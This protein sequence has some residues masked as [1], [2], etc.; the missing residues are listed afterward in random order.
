MRFDYLRLMQEES[1]DLADFLAGLPDDDWNQPT[2]CTGWRV[3]EVV[4]HMAAGHTIALGSYL[5]LLATAGFSADRAADRLA[6]QFAASHGNEAILDEF[7]RGTAGQPKGPAA[8]VPR[9][10]LFTDH[11][12]H[13][14][15]I[16]RPLG[17]PRVI[18][19]QRLTAAL[20]ILARLSGRVG[21][22]ARMR[23]LRVVC[24]DVPFSY[25]HYGAELR[26]GAE[27]LIM[28]LSGRR[29]AVA[30]LHGEGAQL[31]GDRLSAESA[32]RSGQYLRIF[33]APSPADRVSGGQP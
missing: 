29:A 26:G 3:R 14:Q 4:S 19:E 10:E 1:R 12:I 27:A 7:R 9:A 21:S 11:L 24:D 6:R 2:L 17:L 25:G 13:H 23:G 32:A 22:R 30:D 28:A 16:R 8:L 5:V 18:P 15:D 20:R 31:L 33:Q